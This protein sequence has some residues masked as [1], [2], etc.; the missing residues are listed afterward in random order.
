MYADAPEASSL[1]GVSIPLIHHLAGKGSAAPVKTSTK[2]EF[3]YPNV[4]SHNFATPFHD[5][6]HYNAENVSHTRNL[7]LLKDKMAGPYFDLEAIWDE[8][9]FYEFADRSVEHTMSTMVQ[10]PY[11][12]HVPTVSDLARCVLI[13]CWKGG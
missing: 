9:C 13:S 2:K 11:V 6:F 7:T 5:A 1:A 3:F 10:E 4:T 8:H 12:N